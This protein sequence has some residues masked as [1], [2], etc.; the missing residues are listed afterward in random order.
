MASRGSRQAQHGAT[1]EVAPWFASQ[2]TVLEAEKGGPAQPP[3]RPSWS[4]QVLNG[5]A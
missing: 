1:L 5:L 4:L 2:E 3:P